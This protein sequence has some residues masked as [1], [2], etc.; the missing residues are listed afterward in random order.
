M[1]SFF[2]LKTIVAFRDERRHCES[3]VSIA[4]DILK[5]LKV[6]KHSISYP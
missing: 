6:P 2:F 1:A 3:S 4:L 5:V